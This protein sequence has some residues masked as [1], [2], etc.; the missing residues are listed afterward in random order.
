MLLGASLDVDLIMVNQ[1]AHTFSRQQ[2]YMKNN[3]TDEL[4]A[5]KESHFKDTL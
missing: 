4:W 2:G 3:G 1:I 5:W